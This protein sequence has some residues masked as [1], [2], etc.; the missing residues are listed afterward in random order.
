MAGFFGTLRSN[1]GTASTTAVK[2]LEGDETHDEWGPAESPE[3]EE[4]AQQ[5]QF[6]ATNASWAS[7]QST[8][9]W[10]VQNADGQWE[11][12]TTT[13]LAGRMGKWLGDQAIE[14][15]A[16]LNTYLVEQLQILARAPLVGVMMSADSPVDLPRGVQVYAEGRVLYHGIRKKLFAV[17]L[18]HDSGLVESPPAEQLYAL[19]SRLEQRLNPNR[20]VLDGPCFWAIYGPQTLSALSVM[21]S[22]LVEGNLDGKSSQPWWKRVLYW[23]RIWMPTDSWSF[24]RLLEEQFGPGIVFEFAWKYTYTQCLWPIALYCILL[25]VVDPERECGNP[26]WEMAKIGFL[27]WGLFAAFQRR[28]TCRR[29]DAAKPSGVEDSAL[30]SD[31]PVKNPYFDEDA[32]SGAWQLLK[33]TLMAGPALLAFILAVNFTVLLIMQTLV[34]MIFTWGDCG[35]LNCDSPD[36]KHGLLGLLAEISLDLLFLILFELFFLLA[37]A[38]ATWISKLRNYRHLHDFNFSVEMITLVLAII[39]RIETFGIS[40]FFFVPQWEKPPADEV[41]DLTIPCDDLWMGEL[42]LLCLQRR[43]PA[44][45]RRRVFEKT[46][47]GPFVVTPF[48]AILIKVI[49]P[50]VAQWLDRIVRYAA[51]GCWGPCRAPTYGLARILALLFAYDG[52]NV[53]WFQF[54]RSGWPFSEL[55]LVQEKQSILNKVVAKTGGAVGAACRRMWDSWRGKE[56][57]EKVANS[58]RTD[59]KESSTGSVVERPLV[60]E[61]SQAP[62]NVMCHEMDKEELL[63]LMLR[64]CTRRPYEAAQEVLDLEMNFLWVMFFGPVLPMGLVTI[65]AARVLENKF[66]LPKILYVTRRP[67]PEPDRLLRATKRAFVRAVVVGS[68]G[69][70]IGL[71]LLT[72]NDDLWRW[73]SGKRVVAGA[74]ALWLLLSLGITL[75]H[76]DRTLFALLSLEAVFFTAIGFLILWA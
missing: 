17:H 70:S 66:D 62:I 46:M 57:A 76:A 47:N 15:A 41:V 40:A 68:V 4:G 43:L 65:L 71:S 72:Y 59:S 61:R 53:G 58:P 51:H 19:G 35:S 18:N 1:L 67:F 74:V 5:D 26:S 45:M 32:A 23:F 24:L 7:F 28:K 8:F 20:E 63:Q 12:V 16:R 25:Q 22:V 2:A 30:W 3:I 6:G 14:Q 56:C 11:E 38:I 55:V 39:E 29:A 31:T 9:T 44:A 75:A 37:R 64:Q 42:S 54:L 48:L 52:N 50:V 60:E 10:P 27:C 21:E 69:W 49:I 34:Y 73:G 36:V 33:I 13:Q